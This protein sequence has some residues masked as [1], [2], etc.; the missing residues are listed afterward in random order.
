MT[1]QVIK[2]RR[3]SS[4]GRQGRRLRHFLLDRRFQLKYTAMILAVATV[5]SAVLGVFLIDKVRENSRMLQIE[6]AF[7]QAFQTQLAASDARIIFTLIGA[8]AVFLVVL[9]IFCVLITHHMVGPIYVMRRYIRELGTGVLPRV[10]KLRKGDEFVDLFDA[11]VETLSNMERRVIDEIAILE[12]AL[13]AIPQDD[14]VRGDIEAL[15]SKKRAMLP[16]K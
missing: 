5:I 14:P 16:I 11:L 12:K 7:D 13:E 6:A 8:L 15:L 10:R 1:D 9:A 2:A 3:E 4:L